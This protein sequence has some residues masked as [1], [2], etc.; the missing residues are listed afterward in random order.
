MTGK[1]SVVVGGQYGSEAKGAVTAFLANEHPGDRPVHVV[2]VGGPNAGH[3]AYAPDRAPNGRD[4]ENVE[5][6]LR[7]VPVGFVNPHAMLYIGAG[8]EIDLPVLSREISELDE[9]GHR[10]S[11][12][13]Y[14]DRSATIITGTHKNI[15]ADNNLVKRIGSTGKGIGAARAD[16]IMRTAELYGDN[17]AFGGDTGRKLTNALRAGGHVIVEGTQG[18]GLGLHTDNYPQTTSGDCRAIDFLAQAGLSPWTNAVDEFEVIVVFRTR[19]I[20]V[21][22]NSGELKGE[23]TWDALGLPVERT[24]VTQKV[25]RVG[26]WDGDLASSALVANGYPSSEVKV[27]LTML[28]QVQPRLAGLDHMPSTRYE[29]GTD[30][31]NLAEHDAYYDLKELADRYSIDLLGA[32][33]AIV[34]TGPTTMFR[35]GW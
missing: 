12:R 20:R 17:H 21:A 16:R 25:R 5:W 10:V 29:T 7:Q 8:S 3:T 35:T 19:P 30:A 27:A 22:G 11:E 24:T 18:Y 28:D 15:E 26:E 4:G 9:A 34:G 14:I 2:R 1:L 13:L 23:T 33:P 31:G 6:K 32:R